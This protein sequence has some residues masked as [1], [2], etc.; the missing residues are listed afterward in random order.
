MLTITNIYGHG[1]DKSQVSRLEQLGL[2]VRPNI[3]R[4]P[5]SQ[6]CR[7]IDFGNGPS[8]ELIEIEDEREYLDF[9][10]DGMKPYC[11]GISFAFARDSA[12]TLAEIDMMFRHLQ[13]Y[14]LHVNY[15][16]TTDE[17]KP[18]WNYLNFGVPLVRDTFIWLTEYDHPR[19]KPEP[20]PVH[21]NE[22][23]GLLGFVFDLPPRD[24]RELKKLADREFEDGGI[25]IAGLRVWLRSGLQD[26]PETGEKTFPLVA[27]VLKTKTLDAVA[28]GIEGVREAS[29]LSRPALH[30]ETNK[31][32]WD[33]MITTC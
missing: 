23:E 10:L 3:T 31:L 1:F 32:S 30:I 14:D 26:F 29:L 20:K 2:C 8:L 19:P 15:D 24:I 28:R 27:M 12:K 25:E 18:G 16:G 11:P 9:V 17:R 4:F 7:F 21:P 13:P 33:I 5:G 6:M 22:V